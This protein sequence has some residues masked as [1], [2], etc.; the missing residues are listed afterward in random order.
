MSEYVNKESAREREAR[1][2]RAQQMTTGDRAEDGLTD[3]ERDVL[4]RLRAASCAISGLPFQDARARVG[5]AAKS[6]RRLP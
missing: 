6:T 2:A 1:R 3:G 5:R 4:H